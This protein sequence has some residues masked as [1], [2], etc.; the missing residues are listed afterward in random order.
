MIKKNLQK[1]FKKISY[2]FFFQIYGKIKEIINADSDTRIKLKFNKIEEDIIYKIYKIK[3]GRMYTDRIH[4]TAILLENKIVEGASFQLRG[5]KN[6]SAK[7]NIVFE[8]GTPRKLKKLKGVVLSLL[9]GGGGNNNY[10]HW[11]YDVLPRLKLCEEIHQIKDVDYFILPSLEKKFQVETLE[12]LNINQNKTLSS[13]NFRHILSS[14]LIVTDHPYNLTNNFHK[15][16]QNIP[17]WILEWLKE[18]FLKNLNQPKKN[19]P[20]NIYLDR[21][22]TKSIAPQAR[23]LTNEAEVKNLLIKK[24][25]T[26]VKLNDLSFVEQVYHFYN[27]ECVVGLH[28]AG[29]ANLSFCR[30]GTK[31]IEFRT[32]TTGKVIENLA[33][34]NNLEFNSIVCNVKAPDYAKQSGHVKIPLDI[35]EQKMS[36]F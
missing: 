11:L 8:K 16:A 2:L 25:F 20:K 17:I 30:N 29:F 23:S 1:I 34:K 36:E 15:D 14:E 5:N 31:I 19:Y 26:F 12:L 35:L 24:N 33:Q 18:K 28:G 13:K 7:H 21:N 9:T 3:D 32:E 22:D 6:E 4:D 10:W 27:A